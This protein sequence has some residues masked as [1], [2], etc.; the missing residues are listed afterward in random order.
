MAA[1]EAIENLRP[2]RLHPLSIILGINPRHLIQNYI[3]PAFATLAV[4]GFTLTVLAVVGVAALI[5]RVLV[6]QRFTYEFDGE[7]LRVDEGVLARNRRALDVDRI[8]Q[9]EVDRG[10]IQRLFGLATLRVETA[11][12]GSTTGGAVELRVIEH[13]A[14]VRLRTALRAGQ[15]RTNGAIS[16]GA[17]PY[18]TGEEDAPREVLRV[19]LRHVVLGAVTGARLLVFPAVIGGAFQFAGPTTEEWFERFVDEAVRQGLLEGNGGVEVT[20]PVLLGIVALVVAASVIAAAAVGVLR[21][22]GFRIEQ[23]D[24]DLHVSRGL[25]STRSSVLPL[26][27]VQLVL[28]QRNWARRLLG[29][30]VVRVYSAGGSGGGERRVT[31]PLLPDG[32]VESLLPE[33]YPGAT[34]TPPLS[35]HPRNALRRAVFRWVRSTAVVVAAIWIVPVGLLEPIQLPSL[36]LLLFAVVL[37]VVEYRQLAHGLDDEL[38]AARRG[39]LSI[40]TSLAPLTKIQAVTTAANPF[41][42]RLGLATVT[43]HVAGPGGDVEVLDMGAEEAVG[44]HDRLVEHAADPATTD[45]SAGAIAPETAVGR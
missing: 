15:A 6:W 26:R 1:D 2:R 14:A 31:V 29:F 34:G 38:V 37:G 27:R 32:E 16:E 11:S 4:A 44:L 42:R 21:D 45:L 7:V 3:V 13:T 30:A 43:A 22:T 8:Q 36:S 39:A 18:D 35:A 20:L 40:T 41:Q 25:L 28:V 17:T 5:I 12:G 19:P 10:F 23:R 9:V 24:G 33:L